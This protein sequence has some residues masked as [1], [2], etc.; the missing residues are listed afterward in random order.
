MEVAVDEHA[1]VV[2]AGGVQ[3]EVVASGVE[4][5]GE[6]VGDAGESVCEA[7]DLVGPGSVAGS[8]RF[9]VEGCLLYGEGVGGAAVLKTARV[10]DS[11]VMAATVLAANPDRGSYPVTRWDSRCWIASPSMACSSRAKPDDHW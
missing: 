9:L 4:G 5:W 2:P 6:D 11:R 7:R 1:G 3:E 10:P 8:G